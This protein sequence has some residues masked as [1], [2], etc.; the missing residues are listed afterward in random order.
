[1]KRVWDRAYKKYEKAE[2]IYRRLCTVFFIAVVL[3]GGGVL[4]WLTTATPRAELKYFEED[5]VM[6]IPLSVRLG[7]VKS[8]RL[9]PQNLD[10]ISAKISA[11]VHKFA[12]QTQFI[13]KFTIEKLVFNSIEEANKYQAAATQNAA[14]NILLIDSVQWPY[15]S[16]K[17][18]HLGSKFWS[19]AQWDDEDIQKT[20][21][22][23]NFAIRDVMIDVN[24]LISIV[25]R[26]QK[27]A[28]GALEIAS[29]PA[30]QQKRHI[31]DSAALSVMYNVHLIYLHHYSENA[32]REEF[33]SYKSI[34]EEALT[35]AHRFA[36][37]IRNVTDLYV[38]AEHL[39]D[40][41]LSSF[42]TMDVQRR[43]VIE[44]N[45]IANLISGIDASTSTVESSQPL[46]KIV[47]LESEDPIMFLDDHADDT[48]AF[49]IAS[50]GGIVA[51]KRFDEDSDSKLRSSA[52]QNVLGV[53]RVLLGMDSDLDAMHSRDAAPVSDW[54]IERLKL[55]SFVDNT[56]R[57]VSSIEAIH[58]LTGSIDN[59]AVSNYVSQLVNSSVTFLESGIAQM[60]RADSRTLDSILKARF[61]ADKSINEPTLLGLLYFSPDQKLAVYV[62]LV[63]PVL[64]PILSSLRALYQEL[65]ST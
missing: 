56:M 29:L 10:E 36:N 2:F 5:Y 24:H 44:H 20:C 18:V 54:E 8:N 4:W 38:T 52:S 1:M 14:V 7:L 62:P 51:P 55:R 65:R 25:R 46:I 3:C 45:Q 9:S 13:L 26:D 39:W 31:W 63:M 23:I 33:S 42:L 49:A 6:K 40:F 57:C 27:K 19:Y 32:H 34:E 15:F 61:L 12:I 43:T 21:S 59:I 58:Q 48:N 64:M 35:A 22:R 53:L 37:R 50:W 16:S 41:D 11:E 30:A 60:E 47:V 28:M 17:K